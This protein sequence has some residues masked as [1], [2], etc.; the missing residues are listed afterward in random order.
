M[1][2]VCRNP[3]RSVREH[4]EKPQKEAIH[5]LRHAL[6]PIVF[7]ALSLAACGGESFSEFTIEQALD[8]SGEL[9]LIHI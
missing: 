1:S 4:F 6:G 3:G 8:A 2:S 5:M 7:G 9:S